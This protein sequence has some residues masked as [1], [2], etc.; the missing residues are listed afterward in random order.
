[1]QITSKLDLTVKL[2]S[3]F[4]SSC[5]QI[6]MPTKMFPF[7]PGDLVR[8]KAYEHEYGSSEIMFSQGKKKTI[9]KSGSTQMIPPV[10]VVIESV[11]NEN[12]FNELDGVEQISTSKVLCQWFSFERCEFQERWFDTRLLVKNEQDNETQLTEADFQFSLCVTLKT[13]LLSNRQVKEQMKLANTAVVNKDKSIDYVVIHTFDTLNYLPP[14][15][16]VMET[17]KRNPMPPIFD[18]KTGKS[19]R[20]IS[21]WTV[22]CMWYNYKLGK[23]SEQHFAPETL[24]KADD[25]PSLELEAWKK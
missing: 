10:M 13:A 19:R 16:V 8:F 2:Q 5:K 11:W 6:Q 4:F 14:K 24:L 21:K 3:Y 22:K 20:E 1:M 7:I 17:V 25:I 9:I 15:M 12:R 18:K 23:Y